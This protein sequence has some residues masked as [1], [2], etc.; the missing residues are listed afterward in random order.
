MGSFKMKKKRPCQWNR[1]TVSERFLQGLLGNWT[2]NSEGRPN[3]GQIDQDQQQRITL[4]I[5][6]KTDRKAIIIIDFV[7]FKVWLLQCWQPFL[8]LLDFTQ[9]SFLFCFT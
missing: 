5:E 7:H 8:L 1:S 4:K 6:G 9:Q 2:N 3:L